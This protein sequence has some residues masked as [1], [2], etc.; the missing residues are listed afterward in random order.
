MLKPKTYILLFCLCTALTFVSA[1]AAQI[2]PFLGRVKAKDINVRIDSTVSS[3]VICQAQENE[4]VE[5]VA[6]LYDWYK[7]RLPKYAPAYINKEMLELVDAQTA[8]VVKDRVN[9]RLLPSEASPVIGTA[10][11]GEAVNILEFRRDWYKIQPVQNSFGWIHKKFLEKD[12]RSIIPLLS[13][14]EPLPQGQL[15]SSSQQVIVLEGLLKAY[16]RVFGRKAT[17]KLIDKDKKVYLLKGNTA[18]LKS[19][20]RLKVKVTG[21]I[22]SPPKAKYPLIEVDNIEVLN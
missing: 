8:K 4:R 13:K 21:R 16:G 12:A 17:H 22:V 9:I 18:L 10:A 6:E 20:T 11:R 7:I 14:D 19:L 1:R 5:V 3:G 15:I 2:F